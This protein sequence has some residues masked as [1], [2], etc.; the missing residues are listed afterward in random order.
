MILRDFE[1]AYEAYAE[2]QRNMERYW[3]LRWLLQEGI[4]DDGSGGAP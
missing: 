4:S 1:L 2:F 3:C